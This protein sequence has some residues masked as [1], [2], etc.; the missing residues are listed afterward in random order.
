MPVASRKPSLAVRPFEESDY[1]PMVDYFLD[2]EP[3]VLTGMG[4]DTRKMLGREEWL[5]HLLMDH[6]KPDAQ[7]DRFYLAWVRDDDLVGHSSINQI[8]LG[9][10]AHFHLHLWKADMRGAGVGAELVRLSAAFYIERFGFKRLIC[11]PYANNPA[12]NRVL[13][14]AGFRFV[15]RYRTVPTT[16][17]FEQDVNRFELDADD[18]TGSTLSVDHSIM[19]TSS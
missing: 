5:R 15:K 18:C 3:L 7:R 11:E 19:P 9:K 4:I 17:S 6:Q 10:E 14:K 1:G 8:E 2:S 13:P 16:L 12:P